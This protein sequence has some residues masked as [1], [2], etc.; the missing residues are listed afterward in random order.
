MGVRDSKTYL[1]YAASVVVAVILGVMLFQIVTE[2]DIDCSQRLKTLTA[3]SLSAA[4]LQ[5]TS[6]DK[7][8]P[9]NAETQF[10]IGEI[11]QAGRGVR[12]DSS[13]AFAWYL[14]AAQQR[15]A[16]A[17]NRVGVFYDVGTSVPKDYAKALVW[18]HKA[19]DDGSAEAEGNIGIAYDNGWGVPK[20]EH[21]ALEWEIKAADHG[22]ADAAFNVG[23]AYDKGSGIPQDYSK[24][25]EWFRKAA[26]GGSAKAQYALGGYYEQGKGADRN[27]FEAG[28]WF[29]IAARQGYRDAQGYLAKV[30]GF[31]FQ[32]GPEDENIASAC[33]MA[34]MAGDPRAEVKVATFYARGIFL[35]LDQASAVQWYR[36]AAMQ[37][38]PLAQMMLIRMYD[39]GEGVPVDEAE[40]Y[41]W[42]VV[43]EQDT[44]AER[45]RA[46]V[47]PF[48]KM[49]PKLKP[50]IANK[51][52]AEMLKQAQARADEY[53]RKYGR[54]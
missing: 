41:A 16:P 6:L 29:D 49:I 47:E 23:A 31:C 26:D 25:A 38:D 3:G 52:N 35:P 48:R 46:T 37:G 1:I 28:K 15:Y 27:Y 20:D 33:E 44:V 11:Y 13:V 8:L 7:N 43:L 5:C 19:A 18:F 50:A 21:Q 30:R 12:S 40:C 32:G 53:V 54:N 10:K 34:A 42:L 24:A 17:E 22:S 39:K 9:T 51:M 4:D 36:K 45:D 14:K 2:P